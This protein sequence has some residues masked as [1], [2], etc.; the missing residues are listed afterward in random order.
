MHRDIA[1]VSDNCT[2]GNHVSDIIAL[3]G[4]MYPLIY[5]NEMTYNK[6]LAYMPK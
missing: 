2:M 4:T 3:W 5:T 1:T 6:K